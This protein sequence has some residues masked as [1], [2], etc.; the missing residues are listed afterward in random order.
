MNIFKNTEI[1]FSKETTKAIEGLCETYKVATP[2]LLMVFS[3]CKDEG[4]A[5][6]VIDNLNK[7]RPSGFDIMAAYLDIFKTD[8]ESLKNCIIEGSLIKE[9]AEHMKRA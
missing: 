8:S 6:Q 2:I 1:K 5:R 4:E 7:E 3:E 9:V